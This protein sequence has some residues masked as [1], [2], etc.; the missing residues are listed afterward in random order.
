MQGRGFFLWDAPTGKIITS[1]PYSDPRFKKIRLQHLQ[2]IFKNKIAGIDGKRRNI[3][4][5]D[6]K[7][8]KIISTIHP[9]FISQEKIRKY[10]GPIITTY[11]FSLDGKTLYIGTNRKK[12]EI[13][14]FENSFF[15]FGEP[16][17]K[18]IKEVILPQIP[19]IGAILPDPFN[20]KHIYVAGQNNKMIYID[21]LKNSILKEYIADF[22]M[23]RLEGMQI[24]NDKKYILA[25]GF[26]RVYV[27][28]KDNKIQWDIFSGGGL[29]G[30]TFRPNSDEIITIGRTIDVWNV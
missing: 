25:Y 17:V 10:G 21:I 12:I 18:F 15:G 19:K 8:F 14:K 30:A 9:K 28:K 11:T 22:Y 2:Y 4:V 24:S 27:W 16:K 1:I 20:P 29:A 13:W 6:P 5:F 3:V 26:G 23:S 7:K